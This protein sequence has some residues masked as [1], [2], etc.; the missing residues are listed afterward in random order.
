MRTANIRIRKDSNA[1]LTEMRGQFLSAWKS[2][3][4]AG[5]FFEFE[6]PASLFKTLTPKRWDLVEALQSNGPLG[7]R[8]LARA[9]H[10]DVKRVHEDA[11]ALI[12]VGLIEKTEDGKLSVPFGEIRADFVIKAAA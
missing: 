2:G 9:L 8:A 4:Y 5:E 1:A 11:Q 12:E 10:R 7:V 6:S 3:T